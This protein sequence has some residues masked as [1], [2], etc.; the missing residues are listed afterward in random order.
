MIQ[1]VKRLP[2]S[3]TQKL[4]LLV[5]ADCHNEKT[6]QCNPS[7][8]YI[9]DVTGLSNKAVANNLKE[10]RNCKGVTFCS[11]NGANTHYELT[12]ER[13]ILTGKP[14][15][16]V[17]KSD[18]KSGEPSSQVEG[19][20]GVASSEPSSQG[21]VNDVPQTS[22]PGSKS[23]EPGSHKPEGT[24][25]IT[26]NEPAKKPA[27]KPKAPKLTDEEWMASLKTNPEYSGINIDAEFKRAADW[28]TKNPGRQLS[29]PFFINWLSKCEK[30][31][32]IKPKL[33]IPKIGPMFGGLPKGHS[34]L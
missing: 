13:Y 2:T 4:L 11:K 10:L 23:S 26:G 20:A 21:P 24:G 17:H 16:D 12:P 25:N 22:E 7:Y 27:K 31:L 3:P 5:L 33:T 9:M 15:N 14:V 18:N 32:L 34:C 29:R 19:D 8:R 6:G 1:A 28:I 30:P